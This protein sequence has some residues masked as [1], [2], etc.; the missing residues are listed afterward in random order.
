MKFEYKF[1]IKKQKK[2]NYQVLLEEFLEDKFGVSSS[3][4]SVYLY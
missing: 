1:L 2:I 4:I 3:F